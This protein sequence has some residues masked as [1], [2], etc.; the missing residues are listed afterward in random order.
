MAGRLMTMPI[1]LTAHAANLLLRA[2]GT[3]VARGCSVVGH[4]LGSDRE[5]A[6]AEPRDREP[7]RE[8]S[9]LQTPARAGVAAPD[10]RV[11]AP[12]ERVA[13][14]DERV[15]GLAVEVQPQP[16]SDFYAETPPEP[17]HISE[18]PELVEEFA[19]PGAEDGA[20]AE[21]HVQEPWDG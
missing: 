20:G 11:A 3:V 15:A 2:S 13:A 14:P 8:P 1:R 17:A 16:S 12:D 18:E 9:A 5:P 7:A 6:P 4:V 21:V 19:E 10:E